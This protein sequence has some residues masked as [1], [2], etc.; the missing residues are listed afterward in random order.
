MTMGR[1]DRAADLNSGHDRRDPKVADA[2]I[3]KR[4]H[5]R[6]ITPYAPV[7]IGP[8]VQRGLLRW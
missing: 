4:A 1:S 2:D 6:T 8:R 3:A 7:V 5:E